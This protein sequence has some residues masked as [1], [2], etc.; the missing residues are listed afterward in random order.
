MAELPTS[1]QRARRFPLRLALQY[2]GDSG[3]EWHPATTENI[4][5][6]GV[7]FRS[8][9]RV[10]PQTAI[11]F[12]FQVPSQIAGPV[13]L[14]VFGTAYVV[15][16]SQ[17]ARWTRNSRIAAS[18]LQFRLP[19]AD[20]ARRRG[21]PPLTPGVQHKLYNWLAVIVGN[22]ELLLDRSDLSNEV[23]AGIARIQDAATS[24]T[25]GVRRLPL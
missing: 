11:E 18:F 23:R 2:R 6:S 1:D 16:V 17:P 13:P 19:H 4:S 5:L 9:H 12:S 20:A 10:P 24:L 21:N 7:L 25:V 8:R 22:C 3:A 15:R 14:R